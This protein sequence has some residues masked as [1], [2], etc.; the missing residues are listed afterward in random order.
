MERDR[1]E[2]SRTADGSRRTTAA[3]DCSAPVEVAP[4]KRMSL[5]TSNVSAALTSGGRGTDDGLS[6][7]E[8]APPAG[9]CSSGERL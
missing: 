6:G 3:M 4:I 5:C 1:A 9:Q 7:E 8:L 2:R